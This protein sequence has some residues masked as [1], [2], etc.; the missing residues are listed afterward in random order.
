M[1][2]LA[3]WNFRVCGE[4]VITSILIMLVLVSIVTRGTV[5]MQHSSSLVPRLGTRLA[6]FLY[7]YV[8]HDSCYL[9]ALNCT[10][11]FL[12]FDVCEW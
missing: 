6:A 4:A 8:S 12:Y 9:S 7:M 5:V 10:H 11:T 2:Y 3:E 1:L